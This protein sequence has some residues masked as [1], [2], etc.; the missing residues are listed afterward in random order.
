M[1]VPNYKQHT[2]DSLEW[3]T[4]MII[5]VE[6]SNTNEA[7]MPYFKALSSYWPGRIEK[8]DHDPF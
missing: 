3:I 7:V 2:S 8:D 6:P 4:G 1:D 5:K